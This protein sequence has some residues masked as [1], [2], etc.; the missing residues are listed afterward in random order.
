MYRYPQKICYLLLGSA[1]TLLGVIPFAEVANA[2]PIVAVGVT[3]TCRINEEVDDGLLAVN[4]ANTILSSNSE[5]DGAS[6]YITLECEGS[7]N[8]S[9]SAPKQDT[10][11]ITITQF[12]SSGLSA[13]ATS[14]DFSLNIANP[15][16]SLA[17]VTGNPSGKIKVDM[18]ANNNGQ[19]ISP[20]EYKFKVTLTVAPD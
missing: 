19:V 15:G 16:T 6:G 7:T 9:I 18:V 17:N 5:D 20:G 14:Q 1:F 3:S 11:D 8:I 4:T 10:S 13:T 12:P 2:E